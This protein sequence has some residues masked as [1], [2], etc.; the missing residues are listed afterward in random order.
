MKFGLP[1]YYYLDRKVL[2]HQFD[3]QIS[4]LMLLAPPPWLHRHRHWI[5][6]LN[7]GKPNL[8]TT[9]KAKI[10]FPSR[11]VGGFLFEPDLHLSKISPCMA[12]TFW[13][14][15]S[16]VHLTPKSWGT[17]SSP[18]DHAMLVQL[19]LHTYVL[20]VHIVFTRLNV[21]FSLHLGTATAQR[22]ARPSTKR[23]WAHRM[24]SV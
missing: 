21:F 11:S 9:T 18:R 12:A 2:D 13:P 17:R 1:F 3:H 5:K 16:N 23:R 6:D 19:L 14:A 8:D 4:L 24:Q 10:G 15:T 7:M 20:L 22:R